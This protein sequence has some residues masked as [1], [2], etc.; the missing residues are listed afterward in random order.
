MKVKCSNCNSTYNIST[1][2]IS[3]SAGSVLTCARCGKFIK[4][5]FCTSCGVPYSI[6]FSE[7]RASKYSLVCQKCANSF[8]VEFPASSVTAE[9]KEDKKTREE[10]RPVIEKPEVKPPLQSEKPFR[11]AETTARE[12]GPS[13]SYKEIIAMCGTSFTAGRLAISA[14]GMTL[15]FFTVLLASIIGQA[16]TGPDRSPG[17]ALT[18]QLSGL[19][20]VALLNLVF[21]YV[22]AAISRITID[23][24]NS[25]E[26]LR[27]FHAL[28][29]TAARWRPIL[30]SNIILLFL[31]DLILICF[32]NVPLIGPIF[33][34]IFFIILY[35]ITIAAITVWLAAIWFYPSIIAEYRESASDSIRR[36]ILFIRDNAS[37]LIFF[38]PLIIILCA[39]FGTL[40]YYAHTGTVHIV[41][42]L[43]QSIMNDDLTKIFSAMP[44]EFHRISD[45]SLIGTNFRVL[46]SL[47]GNL[48]FS[49]QIGGIIT[50]IS[51]S[52]ISIFLYSILLS[53][54]AT[55]SSHFYMI[56]RNKTDVDDRG[57]IM[58]LLTIVLMLAAILLFRKLYI[59]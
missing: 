56:I 15:F 46:K 18:D 30:A 53:F 9:K 43:S 51:L 6:T 1:D 16:I 52:L 35:F 44:S 42:S 57:R 59:P 41:L 34:S 13:L 11:R 10:R 8:I 17:N 37:E 23:E 24:T 25:G 49:H 2:G 5:A 28:T 4:I 14:A 58:L 12:S 50:G 27:V 7:T 3:K 31:A 45:P 55:I 26:R 22:S 39:I 33:Y 36:L 47:L 21:F 32:G 48:M 40:I 29:G 19:F 54:A 38:I 20:P